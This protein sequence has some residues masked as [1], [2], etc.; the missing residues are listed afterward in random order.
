[1]TWTMCPAKSFV[2][3]MNIKLLGDWTNH[4]EQGATDILIRCKFKSGLPAGDWKV[5]G[6]TSE[7]EGTWEGISSEQNYP[8]YFVVSV[9]L[10][11]GRFGSSS[12]K[13]SGNLN[14]G[15]LVLYTKQFFAHDGTTYLRPKWIV[16]D[17]YSSNQGIAKTISESM[18]QSSSQYA[19]SNTSSSN[20]GSDS[21]T[22]SLEV[23]ATI[24]EGP[25]SLGT[26]AS[27]S[28]TMTTAYT[29]T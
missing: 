16:P 27:T 18:T 28:N 26:T 4:P 23:S 8:S 11:G 10:Y 17:G 29:N 5:V 24:S 3:A 25:V 1:M 6:K 19:F 22:N 13:P 15:G 2:S 20:S 9:G 7:A 12:Q 21:T 14:L